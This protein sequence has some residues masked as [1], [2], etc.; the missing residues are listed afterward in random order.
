[1]NIEEGIAQGIVRHGTPLHDV[2]VG[3]E[4]HPPTKEMM[5]NAAD[6]VRGL[7][8]MTEYVH[9][10]WYRV[11][12]IEAFSLGKASKYVDPFV[13]NIVAATGIPKFMILGKGE[14][15]YSEDTLTLTEDGW[16]PYWEI[17]KSKDK[18]A[19]YNPK[20]GF[21]EYHKPTYFKL[22]H[23]NGQMYHFK[24]SVTDILVTPKHKMFISP[25]EDKRHKAPKTWKL[26]EAKDISL[27]RFR[28]KNWVDWNTDNI[29]EV[30]I[31]EVPYEPQARRENEGSKRIPIDL[32]LEFLGYYISEGSHSGKN[33][34]QYCIE[35]SQN[36]GKKFDKMK[37]CLEK[38]PYTIRIDN[39]VKDGKKGF[40]FNSKSLYHFLDQFGT[41]C[42]DKKIPKKFKD[43]GAEK[44]IIL[45]NALILGDGTRFSLFNKKSTVISYYTSSKQLA[46]DASEIM[47]KCGY[48]VNTSLQKSGKTNEFSVYRINGNLSWK[49]SKFLKKDIKLE[50]YEGMVYCFEVPNHL[51]I[52]KRKGKIAIQG[53]TNKA[54]AQQILRGLN[55]TIEPLQQ[56]LKLMFEKEVLYP[57]MKFNNIKGC[58]YIQ[59][60]EILPEESTDPVKKL[61]LLSKIAINN[62]PLI[63]WG[64]AREIAKLPSLKPGEIEELSM[65]SKPGLYLTSPHARLLQEGEKRSI[66]TKKKYPHVA[67]KH[68][69]LI[70][71]AK[72]EKGNAY[73]IIKLLDPKSIS[74]EEFTAA[75]MR[76]R[77]TDEEREKWW[78]G[79]KVLYIYDVIPVTFYREL[80]KVHVPRGIQKFVKDVQFI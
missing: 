26:C 35:I 31:P 23:Y 63:T 58:P 9:P 67:G 24:N 78:P 6:E 45:L 69:I 56:S 7:N 51:Y 38:L 10:P 49:D 13:D 65:S 42:Y 52:T 30:A 60:N 19:T 18:I 47:L 71:D 72:A 76:H 43:L 32:F 66:V 3:D 28:M 64:E 34:N 74:L 8:Y 37:D 25:L 17:D 27:S 20:T 39:K 50:D 57:L 14:E 68:F 40:R 44:L 77:I 33:H 15:C 73:G 5:D 4:A 54:V 46:D 62:R 79:A 70:S 12:L 59:W 21:L 48:V 80:K 61:E 16:K 2:I 55:M 41:C 11:Q 1:M 75:R 29:G 36:P 53:N 22:Y